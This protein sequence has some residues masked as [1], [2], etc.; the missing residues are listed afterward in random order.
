MYKLLLKPLE[1]IYLKNVLP[2]PAKVF[3][4]PHISLQTMIRMVKFASVFFGF[5]MCFH[6]AQARQI[7]SLST[8]LDSGDKNS[9]P[10]IK[11]HTPLYIPQDIQRHYLRTTRASEN[12]FT[13]PLL[14]PNNQGFSSLLAYYLK[15]F[16]DPFKLKGEEDSFSYRIPVSGKED[17][18]KG[19]KIYV[20]V[21]DIKII[22]APPSPLSPARKGYTK[23]PELKAKMDI[24]PNSVPQHPHKI[25][26][27]TPEMLEQLKPKSKQ[28]LC[29]N[30]AEDLQ[31]EAGAVCTDCTE[32][33][34]EFFNAVQARIRYFDRGKLSSE[35][36]RAGLTETPYDN[37]IETICKTCGNID[38]NNFV[39]YIERRSKEQGV[40]PEVMFSIMFK[41][42]GGVENLR[43]AGCNAK[44]SRH[45]YGLFQLHA[46]NS[47]VLKPRCSL[48]G[49][50][51]R[52]LRQACSHLSEMSDIERRRCLYREN[53][54]RCAANLER[55][56]SQDPALKTMCLKNPYC[57][58]EEALTLLAFKRKSS[59]SDLRSKSWMDLNTSERNDWRVA[60]SK[61]LNSGGYLKWARKRQKKAEGEDRDE[62][63][64]ESLRKYWLRTSLDV[65]TYCKTCEGGKFKN[66]RGGKTQ[67]QFETDGAKV[68]CRRHVGRS[69]RSLAYVEAVTG[70]D[71]TCGLNGSI[72]EKWIN[73]RKQNPVITC[74]SS[75]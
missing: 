53:I 75:Q 8:V 39:R 9:L 47:S 38:P 46:G 50:N 41:E 22:P 55:R 63:D 28:L 66:R 60:L 49:A 44:S 29:E 25:A 70:R 64:F 14:N 19:H 2:K 59:S 35:N 11:A 62:N 42:S 4:I 67:C 33:Q 51:D 72:M 3:W 23:I 74:P 16:T 7:R 45:C 69:V 30:N 20:N 21:N 15:N 54:N 27:M 68:A 10:I 56:K 57:N 36:K 48:E 37:Q 5:C 13:L 61:Y 6:M 18:E 65:D 34:R 40:P 17:Y 1:I 58:F 52:E 31:T 12:V 73:Y 24:D 26:G 43:N 32:H 71:K